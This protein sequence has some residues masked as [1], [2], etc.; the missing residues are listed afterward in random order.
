M[1][2]YL[3]VTN[4]VGAEPTAIPKSRVVR[5]VPN[6]RNPELTEIAWARG[7]GSGITL[8]TVKE[9]LHEVIKRLEE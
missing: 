7:W 2:T 4:Q 3:L 5:V 6:K 8:M 1:K 9:N